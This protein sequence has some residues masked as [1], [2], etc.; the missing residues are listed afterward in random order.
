MKK[1]ILLFISL[2]LFE[3]G[4]VILTVIFDNSF[5]NIIVSILSLPLSLLH[6]SY[7]FYAE[8][9]GYLA[10]FLIIVNVSIHTFVIRLIYKKWIQ[11]K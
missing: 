11:K 8:G 3:C 7:P 1:N 4:M 9:S 5:L 2:F 10:L 6:R